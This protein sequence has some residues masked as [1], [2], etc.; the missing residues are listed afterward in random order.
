MAKTAI[1]TGSAGKKERYEEKLFRDTAKES[2]FSR[3]MGG[4]GNIVHE[5]TN[6]EKGKGD[7]LNFGI[8]MRNT[9]R[10]IVDG[11]LE[12]NEQKLSDY[13]DNVLIHK[14]RLGVRSEGEL[15]EKRAFWDLTD[16]MR[17]NLRVQGGEEMDQLCMDALVNSPTKIFYGGDATSVTPGS[18]DIA[19][20]DKL[21]P[22]LISKVKTW[23][24]NGGNRA[25]TPLRPVRIDGKDY[26]VMVVH[27]DNLYD[28][29]KDSTFHEAR[30]TA[31]IR[32]KENPIFT[33]AYA[34]WDGVVIHSHENVPL[35]TNWGSGSN[36]AGS[37]CTLMGAQA[38]MWAW[39]R[40]PKLVEATFD[41]GDE[42]GIEWSIMAGVKKPK[43][44]SLD[45]GSIGVYVARTQV[46]D[47]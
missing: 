2:Y 44:N 28:L 14:Y 33:G 21:T 16:T 9:N 20:T 24:K 18:G 30:R 17:N 5:K 41:Y 8:V 47:S 31:E 37:K 11:T 26:F 6:L 27:D 10:A 32:G 19:A 25:Q 40:R 29:N 42:I 38:L 7:D 15:D 13:Y 46:S 34:I 43:F 3:F 4:D 12:G 23:G 36:V 1:A 35:Y 39:G 22:D 45:Y